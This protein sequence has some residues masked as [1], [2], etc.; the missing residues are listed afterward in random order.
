M[1]IDIFFR[2]FEYF[3]FIKRTF[4]VLF[5][6]INIHS[7][8]RQKYSTFSQ[9]SPKLLYSHPISYCFLFFSPYLIQN[10]LYLNYT[11]S[12]FKII[13]GSYFYSCHSF[14]IYHTILKLYVILFIQF[15]RK[16]ISFFFPFN[17][18]FNKTPYVYTR[19]KYNDIYY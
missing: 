16:R 17:T 19:S 9:T 1:D 5:A 7:L 6:H 3:S 13:I 14:K 12:C 15:K 4:F 8:Y 11:R 18:P 10:S 2:Y